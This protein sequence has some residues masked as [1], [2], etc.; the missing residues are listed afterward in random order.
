VLDSYVYLKLP[1]DVQK[2]IHSQSSKGPT[3]PLL[4]YCRRELAHRV[5]D[6]LLDADFM[7]AYCHGIVVK[8]YDGI[9]RRLYPRFVTYS[10]DYPEK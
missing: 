8:C 1:D 3:D 4:S 9:W 5:W 6:V 2:H 10:A 7:D